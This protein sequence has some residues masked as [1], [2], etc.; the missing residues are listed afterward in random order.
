[1][2]GG[3]GAVA[4]ALGTALGL[5]DAEQAAGLRQRR[6]R[7]RQ[8][9]QQGRRGLG[10]HARP[11]RG[12]ADIV[13]H[14]QAL[15]RRGRLEKC[16]AGGALSAPPLVARQCRPDAHVCHGSHGAAPRISAAP[17]PP[18]PRRS[19]GVDL[20][21]EDLCERQRQQDVRGAMH[22]PAVAPPGRG[23]S[24]R[25]EAGPVEA[26]VLG[27]AA[28]GGVARELAGTVPGGVGG[29]MAAFVRQGGLWRSCFRGR[30][31]SAADEVVHLRCAAR[32]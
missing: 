5:G 28:L 30:R 9:Q 2:V 25:A 24:A 11:G 32:P 12:Q 29:R 26:R 20:H 19:R 23:E 4:A 31:S 14:C 13:R 1:M 7:H 10:P 15:V 27:V 8:R 6:R 21:P 3:A 18:R 17:P 22:Q 16:A